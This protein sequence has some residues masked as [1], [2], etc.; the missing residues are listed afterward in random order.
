MLRSFAAAVVNRPGVALIAALV[1]FTVVTVLGQAD[2][3]AS[4]PLWYADIA[5]NLS[6]DPAGVF[7]AHENHP[8]VMRI[9]L[10]FPLALIYRLFGVSTLTTNLP[11]LLSALGIIVVIY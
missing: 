5:H 10:T 7:A 2:F 11:A 8:F 1:V 9:G 3:V 4:D 6:R